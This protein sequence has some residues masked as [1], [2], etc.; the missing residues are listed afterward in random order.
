[1]VA[2][3]LTVFDESRHIPENQTISAGCLVQRGNINL[4]VVSGRTR[5]KG[6][7]Y[8]YF[9]KMLVYSVPEIFRY[10]VMI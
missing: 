4:F 7:G 1:M 8:L 6:Q 9:Q 10:M 5:E 3:D 2:Y